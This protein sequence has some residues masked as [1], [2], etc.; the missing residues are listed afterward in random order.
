MAFLLASSNHLQSPSQQTEILS[1]QRPQSALISPKMNVPPQE[2]HLTGQRQQL[3]KSNSSPMVA[4]S[5]QL[6][7]PTTPECPPSPGIGVTGSGKKTM[8][9]KLKSLKNIRRRMSSKSPSLNSKGNANAASLPSG[10]FSVVSGGEHSGITDERSTAGLSS[11]TPRNAGSDHDH[12]AND[13]GVH[14]ADGTT[15][16]MEVPT[17]VLTNRGNPQ[18]AAE[19]YDDRQPLEGNRG[20]SEVDFPSE[21][22][23]IPS[24]ASYGA[25]RQQQN[26]ESM[27]E[28]PTPFEF[29]SDDNFTRRVESYDGQVIVC[30]D[31]KQ[32]TYEVGNY[33][34]GGVAGVV[35]EGKRLRPANEYPPVRM[36]GAGAFY[37]LPGGIVPTAASSG[38]ASPVGAALPPGPPVAMSMTSSSL[39]SVRRRIHLDEAAGIGTGLFEEVH[40]AVVPEAY[41][42]VRGLPSRQTSNGQYVNSPNQVKSAGIFPETNKIYQPEVDDNGGCT[43]FLFAACGNCAGDSTNDVPMNAMNVN[44]MNQNGTANATPQ[45]YLAVDV[46]S[47]E[48]PAAF[49]SNEVESPGNRSAHLVVVDDPDAPNR[50]KREA[51]ALSRNLP[52]ST[53]TSQTS[54]SA[55]LNPRQ[56]SGL[57]EDNDASMMPHLIEDMTETVAIKILNPVGFRLLDPEMLQKAVIVR[58]GTLPVVEADG[59]FKLREENVWWLVNPTSRNLRSLLRKN[60][61]QQQLSGGSSPARPG[62]DEASEESSL[63][64]KRQQSGY[65]QGGVD[66]GTPER[67]LRLSLVATY[68]DPRTS[69]LKELPLPRCVEVWGHPPFAASDDEFEAMMDALMRLNAGVGS[70]IRRKRSSRRM[71]DGRS[72]SF[73]GGKKEEYYDPLSSRRRGSTVYCP[74]LSAYIAVPVVPP[75]YLRWLKQRR[76]A[77]K[78]VRNMMR[79]G[80]HRNVVHLYEVLELV[81]DSKSTMFLILELVRGGELFD[82]ISGNSGSSKQ[83]NVD[84]VTPNDLHEAT[85]RK[86]F[87]ELASGINFIHQCGVAHRDLKPENLLIHTKPIVKKQ[88]VAASDIEDDEERTLK[89]ADF[90]LSAAFEFNPTVAFWPSISRGES[91]ASKWDGGSV[92]EG[93]RL[94]GLP[95]LSPMSEKSTPSKSGLS[96]LLNRVGATALSY[97]TCGSM[98][99]V[100]DGDGSIANDIIDDGIESNVPLRRMT[101]VVGSP[102]YVAPEIISQATI[103]KGDP[104]QGE[105]GNNRSESDSGKK[106]SK[107]SRK[108]GY[109][110]TKADVWSAGVILYAMLFRS[111]PFG[112]DLLR[113]PRYQAFQK[114]YNDARQLQPPLLGKKNRRG[115][116]EYALDPTYDEWDE[117]EM[118]GPHWFFPNEISVEGRDLIVAMLNPDPFDRI[119]VGMVL[120]HPWLQV[121]NKGKSVP[122]APKTGK[123]CLSGT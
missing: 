69:T 120:E 96:P 38:A 39:S 15:L 32:P 107:E 14:P 22:V 76:L 18:G 45:R 81:Q 59:T 70:G 37:P 122:V 67:G 24:A 48:V 87:N 42:D 26:Q 114:W 10:G 74:A 40:R 91:T 4:S 98:T 5:Q 93:S 31:S 75:K 88:G 95:P 7:H 3:L 113:C 84:G 2:T 16:E 30:S 21:A 112:E 90:G 110:G 1:H 55:K 103:E 97:L 36:Q 79:I 121:L 108:S 19:Y 83:K 25:Q 71:Q 106:K 94:S 35:Y 61:S 80:R 101:S 27:E 46:A 85:M 34:G 86:F 89:I 44:E 9:M 105:T 115:V 20:E 78:E 77:T 49:S 123:L 65:S 13:T 102:H 62:E 82:L 33:L 11:L 109:D 60:S 23:G 116:P 12:S 104:R 73:S 53:E 117:E 54:S 56:R 6:F 68:V 8:T 58:E 111:L 99:N 43:S 64:I 100:C 51:R 28:D 50:S 41:Y 17:S 47:I 57:V 118:L 66:R 63:N 72:P 29:I 52:Q 119:S 92:W